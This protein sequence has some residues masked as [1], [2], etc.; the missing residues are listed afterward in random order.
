MEKDEEL[1]GE[2]QIRM[3]ATK[4]M[5]EGNKFQV[6]NNTIYVML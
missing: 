6:I 3:K 1:E 5:Y 4:H 2:E